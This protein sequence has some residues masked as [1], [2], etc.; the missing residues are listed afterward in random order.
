[1]SL[2]PLHRV[3]DDKRLIIFNHHAL[4][5]WLLMALHV[6]AKAINEPVSNLMGL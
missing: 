2:N 4:Q 3:A 6:H 5:R 1:M